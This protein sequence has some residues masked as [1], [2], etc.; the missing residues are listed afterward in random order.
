MNYNLQQ[1]K[2]TY[3]EEISLRELWNIGYILTIFD[4]IFVEVALALSL[5]K[6]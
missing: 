4:R 3:E 6:T 1:K 2:Y 5:I